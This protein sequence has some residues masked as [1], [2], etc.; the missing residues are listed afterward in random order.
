MADRQETRFSLG[1]KLGMAAVA[2]AMLL[3]LVSPVLA[4]VPLAAFLLLCLLAPFVPGFSFFL[5]VI[6]HGRPESGGVALTFDDGPDPDSTPVLLD[7]LARHRLKA[8]FFVVAERAARHPGLVRRIVAEGHTVGNHSLRHDNL[9]MLRRQKTLAGDI[10]AAQA[11]LAGLGVRPLVFRPPVGIT[12][13]R[14]GRILAREG[15]VAVNYSCRAFDRGN[16]N[17]HDLARKIL[18]NLKPGDIIMLHD[19]PPGRRQERRQWQDEL[20][21]LFRRLG[22]EQVVLPLAELIGRP[23]MGETRPGR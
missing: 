2:A 10:R 7:L 15:L 12:N 1:E 20:E 19:L 9:L 17:I 5:P 21:L 18:R 16:R 3:A 13:P 11:I 8:T 23:V 14:L 6:S 4:M 22:Q